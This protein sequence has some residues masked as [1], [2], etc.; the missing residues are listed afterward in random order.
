MAPSRPGVG[1][2]CI[3]AGGGGTDSGKVPIKMNPATITCGEMKIWL[4]RSISCIQDVRNKLAK[5][6]FALRETGKVADSL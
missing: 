4:E 3:K 6:A 2:E 1:P 5:A